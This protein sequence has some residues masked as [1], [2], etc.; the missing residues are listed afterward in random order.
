MFEKVKEH[1]KISFTVL[2]FDTEFEEGKRREKR[3][4][5]SMIAPSIESVKVLSGGGSHFY[6]P[7]Q[8]SCNQNVKYE[9]FIP[10]LQL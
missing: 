8:K 2:E 10:V 1:L 3:G 4:K 6:R 7:T 5:Y 9:Y